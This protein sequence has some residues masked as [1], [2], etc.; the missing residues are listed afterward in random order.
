M[1]AKELLGGVFYIN[2]DHR[3][4]RRAEIENECAR[5]GITNVQRIP[6]VPTDPGYIGCGLAHEAAVKAGRGLKNVL[7]FE[8]D[9]QFLVEPEEFWSSLED[10][11]KEQFDVIMLGCNLRNSEPWPSNDKLVR[12]LFGATGS[13]YLINGHMID[14]IA[15]LFESSNVQL[16][17]THKHWLYANDACWR[18]LQETGCW[19]TF[20]KRIGKQRASYSDNNKAFVDRDDC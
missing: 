20:K 3:T 9:F 12:V 11:M 1:A 16:A 8:D 4:D 6:G 14:R 19:L 7:I 15:D 18:P 13:G 17:A 5:M 10:A 2:L